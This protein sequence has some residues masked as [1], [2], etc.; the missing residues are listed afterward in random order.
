MSKSIAPRGA[1]LLLS[2]LLFSCAGMPELVPP[3]L[4]TTRPPITP[5]T[6]EVQRKL[7]EGARF[8][9]EKTELEIFG[10]RFNMDCTG[11]VLAIYWYAG[12]DLA[13][14]FPKYDGNGV[15]RLYRSLEREKLLYTNSRPLTGDIVFWDNTYD[16]NRDGLWNDPLTHVGMVVQTGEGGLIEYVHLNNSEGIVIERMNLLQPGVHE[17]LV[18]GEI[19]ILNSPIRLKRPGGRHPR[20]WLAGQ[21]YRALGMGYL[22]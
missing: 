7:A 21:L 8:V 13:R 10:R 2:V 14:D 15:T 3:L 16:R 1:L 6:A 5:E 17:K 4:P 9:L 18:M 11:V 20:L 22:F 12:I 19:R